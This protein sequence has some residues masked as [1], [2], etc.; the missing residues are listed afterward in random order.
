MTENKTRDFLIQA[1]KDFD[2]RNGYISSRNFNVSNEFLLSIY[3]ALYGNKIPSDEE[4]KKMNDLIVGNYGRRFECNGD[5]DNAYRCFTICDSQPGMF[6]YYKAKGDIKTGIDILIKNENVQN[7]Y[8]LGCHY[9]NNG[10]GML[11]KKYFKYI[12]HHRHHIDQIPDYILKE[13]VMED[14]DYQYDKF[15]KFQTIKNELKF[16]I[17]NKHLRLIVLS[18]HVFIS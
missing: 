9:Y 18:Y 1:I 10:D 5:W 17:P 8:Q 15:I 7:M 6:R 2:S 14:Q 12:F 11:A 4:L 16:V 13:I 3:D